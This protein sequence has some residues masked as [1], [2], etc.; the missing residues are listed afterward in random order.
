LSD[1]P[2]FPSSASPVISCLVRAMLETSP[3]RRPQPYLAATVCQLLLWAPSDWCR[4]QT[5]SGQEILQWLLA[6][7]TKVMCEKRWASTGGAQF[8]YQMVATFLA[9]S[10]LANIRQSIQWIH[11]CTES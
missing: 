3:S 2:P 6:M 9:R 1:L 4:H 5:P 8:E 11:D 10:S 7:T